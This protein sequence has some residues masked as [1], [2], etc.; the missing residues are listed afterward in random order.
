[1][2]LTKYSVVDVL[3]N[4]RRLQAS[5]SVLAARGLNQE[6]NQSPDCK[7]VY[8][9]FDSRDEGLVT[10]NE[11]S[12]G[13]SRVREAPVAFREKLSLVVIIRNGY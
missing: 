13:I 9:L 4:L 6:R 11:F 5:A 2:L 3:L 1:M 8:L 12:Y 10:W 7:F